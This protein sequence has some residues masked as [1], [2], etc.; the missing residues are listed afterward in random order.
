MI[1]AMRF[2]GLVFAGAA[3]LTV[4]CAEPPDPSAPPRGNVLLVTLDTLRADRLGCYGNAEI[5][6]PHLD[7]L[8]EESTLFENAFSPVPAT[9]PSHCSIMTGNYPLHHGVHDN[10]MY[11]L[12]DEALTLAE[13]LSEG[14]MRTGAFVAAFVLDAQ[15]NLDQGF[16]HY[17]AEVDRPLSDQTPQPPDS[18]PEGWRRWLGQLSTAY[19][20]R[21]D[22]VTDRAITWVESDDGRPFFLWVHYFDPHQ[23]YQAPEPWTTHYDPGY[24]GP[25]RG[26]RT[27]YIQMRRSDRREG[28]SRDW[29][30][31]DRHMIAR[32]DGE[33]SYLDGQ[34]GRLFEALRSAG[35][36]DDTLVIVVADHGESF[37]EHG[38]QFWEHNATVFDEVLRVPLLVRR[39]DGLG[40]GRREPGLVRTIDIAP[41]I[42]DWALGSAPDG[43]QGRSLLG[44][45]E[46]KDAEAPGEIVVQALRGRQVMPTGHSFLGL[47]TREFKLVLRLDRAERPIDV[48][49]FDLREDPAERDPTAGGQARRRVDALLERLEGRRRSLSR[50]RPAATRELDELTSDAL[51]ALGYVE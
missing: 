37:G 4:S 40:R 23:P 39:P 25:L 32:Y 3:L 36:W 8:A 19:H 24:D 15:F 18:A 27:T 26:D 5:E 47:R 30:R 20:R 12:E 44:L 6:T 42:L 21:A 10:G 33:I 51:Q 16:E 41:T 38:R 45:T 48:S 7:R 28:T 29:S 34:L 11:A 14:G 35:R 43:M 49:L 50:V 1:S 31:E 46:G 17:D 13:I 2:A 22:A 9:L